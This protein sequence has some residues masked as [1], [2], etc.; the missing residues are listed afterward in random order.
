MELIRF[1]ED[2]LKGDLPGWTAQRK[3][4]P[5]GRE[6]VAVYDE[7][8]PAS[9]LIA[10]YQ[11]EGEWVFPLI[12]RT[13]DGFA[14]S[15]QI[16][17][18]GGRQEHA[19]NDIETALR[20]AHEEVNITPELV[21]ILGVTSALPIPVSNHLVQP[22]VGFTMEEPDFIPDPKEVAEIFQVSLS[23]LCDHEVQFE[24]RHFKDRDWKIPYFEIENHKVWGATAMILS[25]FRTIVSKVI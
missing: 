6:Q 21:K 20:E 10:L 13:V 19:E 11:K 16:A 7:L 24:E 15:G 5:E 14:H 17:L 9:V 4:I 12:Q 22:V 18:P 3:M 8:H 25:E 2:R 1:I 23:A